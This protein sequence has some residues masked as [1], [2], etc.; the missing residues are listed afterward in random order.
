LA[1]EISIF[2]EFKSRS[3]DASLIATFNA[4]LPFYENV[5]L[6][7]LIA[8]GCLHNLV[9]MDARQCGAV[10]EVEGV[11]PRRAGRDYSLMPVKAGSSFHPK[12]ICWLRAV[13][14]YCW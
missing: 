14:A 5:L 4:F 12:I 7:R 9:M 2:D 13:M 6:R 1:K 11:R 10:L 3:Y 8:K